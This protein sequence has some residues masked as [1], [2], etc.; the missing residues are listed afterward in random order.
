MHQSEQLAIAPFFT[1]HG[2]YYFAAA[3]AAT[4]MAPMFNRTML[5]GFR[6]VVIGKILRTNFSHAVRPR[7]E[8]CTFSLD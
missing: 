7:G 4:A 3:A 2:K 5:L 6:V 8:L 1:L